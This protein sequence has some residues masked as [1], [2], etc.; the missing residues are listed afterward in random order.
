[1]ASPGVQWSATKQ[2]E[3][4]MNSRK[5][6]LALAAG[7]SLLCAAP[8]FANPP[9]YGPAYGW[10]AR[11]VYPHYYYRAPAYAPAY[12]YYA[13]PPVYVAPPPPVVYYPPPRP[14]IY[15]QIPVGPGFQV[16]FRFGL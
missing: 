3:T 16:G 4:R 2:K 5:I 9:P 13:A 10:R 14:A 6:A 11:P 7:A 1:M 8:A 12:V 15:G